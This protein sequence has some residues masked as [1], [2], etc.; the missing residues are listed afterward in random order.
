MKVSTVEEMRA[1]DGKAI[2][3]YGI[4][5]ELLM[6]N[7]G[8]A[9]ARVILEHMDTN[10]ARFVIV[11]GSGNNGGDGLVIARKLHSQGGLVQVVL[12]GD[13]SRFRGAAAVNYEICTQ[14][15]LPM[16]RVDSVERF[17]DIILSADVIVDA[18]LG[19]GLSK[20]V[21]GIYA[22]MIDQI[23]SSGL[24]VVSVDIPSG[25]NG[26]TGQIMGT[27]VDADLTVSL[28]LPK[29]GNLLYPGYAFGG[30]LFVS[31][32]SFPPELTDAGDIRTA[33]NVPPA[34]PVRTE[35][36]HK[37]TFGDVLFI[38]G[39][40][41][42]TGA[43]YFAAMSFL[44]AG[45]G[46]SRLAAPAPVVQA[47]GGG[48]EIVFM[49]QPATESG[50]ISKDSVPVLLAQA[51]ECDMTVIGP[52]LSLDP[53]IPKLIGKLLPDIERPVLI[54]GDGL[55][56]VCPLK[57]LIQQ[58]RG[59]TIMTP[60][61]GEMARL[62]D[63]PIGDVLHD[64]VTILQRTAASYNAIIVLKGA[65]SLI[66]LPD[67][68]V[69]I[70]LSGNSGMASAGS[71]DVLTGTIAAMFGLGLPVAEAVQAGVFMHGFAGDLAAEEY[72]EDGLT[73]GSVLEMLPEA[74][75]LYRSEYETLFED[76]YGVI[77]T[78]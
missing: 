73:A 75:L 63:I 71:G 64:P 1:L 9:V 32:I 59:D 74:T 50:A 24:P 2:S 46:Y 60:H 15:G 16:E 58:R 44:K 52:G 7:A 54:D 77:E 33:V 61:P 21:S 25:V 69:F 55:T 36:G 39:A 76:Y 5:D 28:G 51:G 48:S 49:P 18:L 57:E 40:A 6:E 42:Y 27:A 66:G 78:V 62:A 13:P 17:D 43:P 41:S 29:L 20:D 70:N 67:G 23:K 37:G 72:G 31:H 65:H 3:A 35:W 8:L 34:L 38:A 56:A 14:L 19:T 47:L 68:R 12:A 53:D 22:A 11:C 4:T 10:E 26:N 45:G 30:A